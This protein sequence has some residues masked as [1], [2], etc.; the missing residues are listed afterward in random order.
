MDKNGHKKTPNCGKGGVHYT[1]SITAYYYCKKKKK[2]L[3]CGMSDYNPKEA[4]Y[5]ESLAGNNG[6]NTFPSY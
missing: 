3:L 5:W 1:L 4:E 2:M 6:N